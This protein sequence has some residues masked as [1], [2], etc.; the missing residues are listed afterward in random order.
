MTQQKP[1][2]TGINLVVQNI[3]QQYPVQLDF[4]ECGSFINYSSA[5]SYVAR[6]RGQFPVRVRQ[7][8]G[9]L[10]CHTADLI[11]YIENGV[12]QAEMSVSPI[13]KKCKE[14]KVGRPTKRE[15]LDAAARGLTVKQLRDSK[16][17]EK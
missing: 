3:L 5:A 17:G 12:N 8:G 15:R 1:M 16:E 2:S 6:S 7:Q 9:R 10:V 13:R 4:V 11:N 14:G